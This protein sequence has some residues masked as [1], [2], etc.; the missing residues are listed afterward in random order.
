MIQKLKQ[1]S[2]KYYAFLVASLLL[3]LAGFFIYATRYQTSFFSFLAL[4]LIINI[5]LLSLFYRRLKQK[6]S[7]LK[8]QREDFFEKANVL[9]ED[10]QKEENAINAFR[11]KIVAY[12]QLKWLVEKLSM[13][14]S[15]ED[16]AQTL[17]REIGKIFEYG[18]VTV[19]LYQ[20]DASSGELGI[21][22]A[23][24]GLHSVNIK[25][26]RGDVIDHWVMKSLQPIHLEDTRNDFRFDIE[27]LEKE[28][29]RPVRSVLIAPMVI[30][31]KLIGIL[32]MDSPVPL[33][34]HKD[35][36]RF[37]STVAGVA[38]VALENALLY[39]RVEDMAIRDS[40]TALYLRRYLIDRLQE[41]I[42]RHLRR[43]K[44]MA[45]IMFDLD[46]FKKYNDT[47]GHTAGDLVLKHVAML[48]KEHFHSPG[49]LLCRYGGEEFCVVLSEC[50]KEKALAQARGFVK[51][52][53][54]EVVVLRREKTPVTISGGVVV[55]PDEA[56]TKEELIQRADQLLYEAKRM[57]RNRI[58]ST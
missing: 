20:V 32:R 42:T 8:I 40:L 44:T 57:G 23:E 41:E 7:E 1:R 58:C 22:V 54:S 51:L 18:D 36:L 31:H 39:D 9:K 37:L 10:L 35:D 12:S 25:T 53:E 47:F 30:H 46:H 17:C 49:N 34:F 21:V 24:R 19:I 50:T 45:F 15:L 6:K 4:A 52:V 29:E 33:K 28:A 5:I 16:S 14:L 56:R 26:K 43:D 48:M 11:Q 55:F 13:C 3:P 2:F 38:A 27:K